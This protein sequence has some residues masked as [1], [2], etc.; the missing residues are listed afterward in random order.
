MFTATSDP[1]AP[2][3]LEKVTKPMSKHIHIIC[4]WVSEKV[5]DNELQLSYVPSPVNAVD[6]FTKALYKPAFKML[7][8]KLGLRKQDV[9]LRIVE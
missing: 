5:E 8:D 1:S 7:R 9:E 3:Q 6:L 4:C 2:P